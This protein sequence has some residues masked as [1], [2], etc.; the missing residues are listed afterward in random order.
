MK[1]E[2]LTPTQTRT[3]EA[4]GRGYRVT[5][6]GKLIGP[7]GE[8]SVGLYGTQRYPTFSTNWGGR[9]VSLPIHK[10]AA[11]CF[12][13]AESFKE[14][15]VVRHKNGNTLDFSQDNIKL[16]SHSDNNMDKDPD[17]RKASAVKARASQGVVPRNAKLL[18][19]DVRA[20]RLEYE[21]LNGKKAPNGF[22]KRLT[23][24]F[25]VSRTV[26]NKIIRGEY[27]ASYSD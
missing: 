19:E 22:T 3:L 24:K 5:D 1:V 16:G 11:F 8:L 2:E 18:E 26:I 20:I 4:Y 7:K 25:G 9:V 10:F 23:E 12:Y 6:G 15:L 17:I 21:S 27:Y 14:G 13:G